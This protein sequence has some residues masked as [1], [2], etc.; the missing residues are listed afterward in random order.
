MAAVGAVVGHDRKTVGAGPE[1][2]LKDQQVLAAE[3]DDGG[4]VRA[5]AVELLGHGHGDGAADAAA[6]DADLLNALGVGGNAERADKVLN[7]FA[8]VLGI[9]QGGRRADNLENDLH[10]ALF[11][12]GS[13]N[14]QRNAFTFF[15]DAEN[16]ELAGFRFF[17]DQRRKDLHLRHGR[18]QLSFVQNLIHSIRP[19]HNRFCAVGTILCSSTRRK[20]FLIHII[21]KHSKS[22]P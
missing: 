1:L 6:H 2:V 11:R 12:V 15:V 3:A 9:Q 5:E 19:L 18:I 17:C 7:I 13:G 10:A 16:D 8:L 21:P 20:S 22:Q 4:N 14:R